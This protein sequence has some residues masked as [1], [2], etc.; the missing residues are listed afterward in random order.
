MNI[1]LSFQLSAF[2]LLPRETKAITT[3][4]R[5]SAHPIRATRREKEEGGEETRAMA[6]LSLQSERR[7][8]LFACFPAGQTSFSNVCLHQLAMHEQSGGQTGNGGHSR[9]GLLEGCDEEKIE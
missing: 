1:G 6:T 5:Q 8:F 3:R 9:G 7:I 2:I 4:V